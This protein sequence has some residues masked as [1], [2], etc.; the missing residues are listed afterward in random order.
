[1][2]MFLDIEASSL[3]RSG[4]PD[5]GCLIDEAGRGEGHLIR[6]DGSWL[7]E[8]ARD[9]GRSHESTTVHGISLGM[10]MREGTPARVVAWCAAEVL[11]RSDL[12]ICSDSLGHDGGWLRMLLRAGDVAGSPCMV[13]AR[14]AYALT[15][16]PLRALSS[17]GPIV[18]AEEAECWL[19]ERMWEIVMRATTADAWRP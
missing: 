14:A 19:Q 7:N 12:M 6:L 1:M 18:L 17:H 16:Q 15:C 10:L 13:D 8:A 4:Y 3:R 2:I 5:R 11:C 9:P